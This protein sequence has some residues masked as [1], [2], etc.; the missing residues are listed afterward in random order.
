M[1]RRAFDHRLM[2]RDGGLLRSLRDI[3]YIA[4]ERDDRLP[5]SPA[6]DPGG[7]NSGDAALDLEA[8]LLQDGGEVLGS[9]VLLKSELAEAEDAVYHDLRLLLHGVDLAGEIGLH[10][11][12]FFGRDLGLAEGERRKGEE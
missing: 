1:A 10:G 7:G 11:S 5:R 12:F 8:F 3:V 6:R 9:L 4:A 2:P